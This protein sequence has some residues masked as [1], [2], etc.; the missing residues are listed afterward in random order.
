MFVVLF[1]QLA[2]ACMTNTAPDDPIAGIHWIAVPKT[3]YDADPELFERHAQ[4]SNL[5]SHAFAVVAIVLDQ[6]LKVQ[7]FLWKRFSISRRRLSR[8]FFIL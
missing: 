6:M 3:L 4:F 7:R 8:L 5:K 2:F 1:A